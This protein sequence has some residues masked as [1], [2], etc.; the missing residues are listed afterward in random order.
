MAEGDQYSDCEN[1]QISIE[2]LLKKLIVEDVNG[3]PCLK[4]CGGP[5]QSKLAWSTTGDQ[6]QNMVIVQDTET[7]IELINQ[8]F[9][10]LNASNIIFD[11]VNNWID[12]SGVADKAWL[13]VVTSYLGVLGDAD[14]TPSFRLYPDRND[15]N[16]FFTAHGQSSTQKNGKTSSYTT[17]AFNGNADVMR[18]Y[19]ETDKNETLSVKSIRVK[20]DLP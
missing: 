10:E 17:E 6:E 19:I 4:T 5:S 16:T 8:P 13:T 14:V 3:D 2:S 7:L 9:I 11:T 15:L 1:K 12:I 18:I 20:I